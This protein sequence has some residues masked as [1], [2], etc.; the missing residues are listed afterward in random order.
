MR[1]CTGKESLFCY[2]YDVMTSSLQ[3]KH[4][5]INWT[6]LKSDSTIKIQNVHFLAKVNV[7]KLVS[8]FCSR[9]I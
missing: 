8:L 3:N 9:N 5:Y 4:N 6:S 1:P 7:L 2:A